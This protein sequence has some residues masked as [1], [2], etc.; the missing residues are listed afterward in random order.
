MTTRNIDLPAIPN[1][2]YFQYKHYLVTKDKQSEERYNLYLW[3][4]EPTSME[5]NSNG[6]IEA[7]QKYGIKLSRHRYSCVIGQKE[8]VS[9]NYFNG[10]SYSDLV[11]TLVFNNFTIDFGNELFEKNPFSSD[12]VITAPEP[13]FPGIINRHDFQFKH[14]FIVQSKTRMETYLLYLW[15]YEPASV[16]VNSQGNIEAYQ[17]Y[18]RKLERHKYSYTIGQNNWV[19]DNISNT[20]SFNDLTETLVYNNFAMDFGNVH[21][22]NNPLSND[23]VIPATEPKFPEI[24]NR[25]DFQ[26]KNYF[27]VQSKDQMEVYFLYLWAYEPAYFDV[28]DDGNLEV[29]QKYGKKLD[30]FS[31]HRY[32][33]RIGSDRWNSD[34]IYN[35]IKYSDFA[36][37]L[38]YNNFTL[39]VGEDHYEK[40][41]LPNDGVVPAVEPL[42]PTMPQRGDFQYKHYLILQDK[43]LLE[44]Y[45]LYLWEYEPTFMKVNEKGYIAAYQKFGKELDRYGRCR[46]YYTIGDSQWNIG[47]TSNN[48]LY[49][50]FTDALVYN[51]FPINLSCDYFGKNEQPNDGVVPAVIPE[52]PPVPEISGEDNFYKYYLLIQD[53]ITLERYT[54]YML[55]EKPFNCQI[56]EKDIVQFLDQQNKQIEIKACSYT[57][58]NSNW[59]SAQRVLN[60]N[61][62]YISHFIDYCNFDI[63][64]IDSPSGNSRYTIEAP[65][66][67]Y[68]N[69]GI[70]MECVRDGWTKVNGKWY[71]YK[72]GL[73]QSGWL[74]SD[75]LRSGLTYYLDK[76]N[77]DQ[78][79]DNKYLYDKGHCYIL[80]KGGVMATSNQKMGDVEIIVTL[81]GE[82]TGVNPECEYFCIKGERTVKIYDDIDKKKIREVGSFS[83]TD[84]IK[85]FLPHIIKARSDVNS[86]NDVAVPFI[87]VQYDGTKKGWVRVSE[88][89]EIREL[90]FYDTTDYAVDP[91][92]LEI[93]K[94]KCEDTNVGNMYK[95]NGL[96]IFA[97]EGLGSYSG[98][99]NPDLFFIKK[100]NKIEKG[101]GRYGALIVVTIGNKVV[102][103]TKNASTLP[104]V[105]HTNIEID[106]NG[107]KEYMGTAIIPDNVYKI[108]TLRHQSY[109]PAFG[110][111]TIDDSGFLPNSRAHI[112]EKYRVK[113]GGVTK[114]L[115][116]GVNIHTAPT[117]VGDLY[118]TACHTISSQSYVPFL[119]TSGCVDEDDS[120]AWCLSS[121]EIESSLKFRGE[122][123]YPA[124]GD[125]VGIRDKNGQ[126]YSRDIEGMNM[127]VELFSELSDDAITQAKRTRGNLGEKRGENREDLDKSNYFWF[128]ELLGGMFKNDDLTGY[129]VVDRSQ[130]DKELK[131]LFYL[132]DIRER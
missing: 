74:R 99:G 107:T 21:Y 121:M 116:T 108:V 8:W 12:Q 126:L 16:E 2:H 62:V 80:G 88:I 51:N 45:F 124:N 24:M 106:K 10:I 115:A 98:E 61:S 53:T 27:I 82:V 69:D 123:A 120:M 46:Y 28:A 14:Y 63:N 55:K 132:N 102:F 34:N 84:R 44:R 79:S 86:R 83:K 68:P 43:S 71:Y 105:L 66:H 56:T 92:A 81:N 31:R 30:R 90:G 129:Y 38:V 23:Q 91:I 65:G 25:H 3:N 22:K 77:N 78:R 128:M 50:E 6:Y 118:S 89:D 15:N 130:M 97:F 7:Y 103:T 87:A 9:D 36:D 131:D 101:K 37:T 110:C 19:S 109:Y 93:M 13:D 75:R 1:R 96:C 127:K 113:D 112:T 95:N 17:K 72:D 94:K 60:I 5:V 119:T 85:A 57:L 29:Y 111:Q 70:G 59:S 52:F 18:G 33:Y 49:E 117:K 41:L 48:I 20:I 104:N 54:L 67:S 114:Y 58:G 35:D 42:F 125:P 4:Y 122:R 47:N 32:Y 11:E 39:D 100:D 64:S 76:A 40:N 26:Y 73:K